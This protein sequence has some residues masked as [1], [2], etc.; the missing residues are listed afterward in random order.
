MKPTEYLTYLERYYGI[1]IWNPQT[2][3]FPEGFRVGYQA[4][5]NGE[6]VEKNWSQMK[7]DG[8]LFGYLTVYTKMAIERLKTTSNEI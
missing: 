5:K 8:W 7:F 1:N 6:M 3:Q 2:M 4:F